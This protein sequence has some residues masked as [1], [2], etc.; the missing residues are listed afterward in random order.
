MNNLIIEKPKDAFK[1]E[2]SKR[3]YSVAIAL[4]NEGEDS[5]A[6]TQAN[7]ALNNL[8]EIRKSQPSNVEYQIE[9]ARV[10]RTLAQLHEKPG[11]TEKTIEYSREALSL[12][13]VLLETDKDLE[14]DNSFKITHLLSVARDYG[15]LGRNLANLKDQFNLDEATECIKK[16]QIKY[17]EALD[18]NPS[19]ENALKGYEW[20][21]DFLSKR[22]PKKTS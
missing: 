9:T 16:S 14:N 7:L 15:L 12:S 6:R 21:K 2:L 17:K 8:K 4:N 22:I 19:N 11:D 5:A 1:H 18:E 13:E 10:F 20:A 3:Y